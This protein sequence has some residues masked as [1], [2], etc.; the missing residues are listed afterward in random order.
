M[1]AWTVTMG[2][3][4]SKPEG[5][6]VPAQAPKTRW[7]G[8]GLGCVALLLACGL[9][10]LAGL[11]YGMAHPNNQGNAV[12]QSVLIGAPLVTMLLGACWVAFR[13]RGPK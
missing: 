5:D 3:E 10:V 7:V 6:Q 1:A 4:A 13:S 8:T 9:A 11:A 2:P 12:F